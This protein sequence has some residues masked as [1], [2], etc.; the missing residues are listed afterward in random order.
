MAN[1]LLAFFK[2]RFTFTLHSLS[3]NFHFHCYPTICTARPKA[4]LI[5]PEC[6]LGEGDF[7]NWFDI[8]LISGYDVLHLFNETISWPYDRKESDGVYVCT[9]HLGESFTLSNNETLTVPK[10]ANPIVITVNPNVRR[11]TSK[12]DFDCQ[13]RD[14]RLDPN[15][16]IEISWQRVQDASHLFEPHDNMLLGVRHPARLETIIY[17]CVVSTRDKEVRA[18][19]RFL[20]GENLIR[21]E[22]PDGVLH[23]L[24]SQTIACILREDT[25][26]NGTFTMTDLYSRTHLL[27]I[28]VDSLPTRIEPPSKM[29]VYPLP[30]STV[31]SCTFTNKWNQTWQEY[32][33]VEIRRESH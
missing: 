29:S 20:V 10:D 16:P 11:L 30:G 24:S 14:W 17:E 18:H 5:A 1:R 13:V 33:T 9:V 8:Q 7:N 15:T 27:S 22:P 25:E 12:Q 4:H 21:F 28:S 3:L 32:L 26:S 31:V 6:F 19:T 2:C 23:V